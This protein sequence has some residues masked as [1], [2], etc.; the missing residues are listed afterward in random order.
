MNQ[1]SHNKW[2]GMSMNPKVALFLCVAFGVWAKANAQSAP[3]TT[4]TLMAAC[5][6][7]ISSDPEKRR[8]KGD[9]IIVQNGILRNC[10]VEKLH[11]AYK[12]EPKPAFGGSFQFVLATLA[13][14]REE[15]ISGYLVTILDTQLTGRPPDGVHVTTLGYYPV[16]SALVQIRSKT[17][18][19]DLFHR[20]AYAADERL[21]RLIT[22]VLAETNGRDVALFLLQPRLERVKKLSDDATAQTGRPFVFPEHKNLERMKQLL[23]SKDEIVPPLPFAAAPKEA[24]K[25]DA[26][27]FGAP[28]NE[29]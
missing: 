3:Q 22:W 10:L 26:N 14:M 9:F 20:T 25:G 13:D 12:R 7:L 28:V 8:G 21:L 15:S 29:K 16:A 18:N 5:D 23:E 17:L 11:E 24:P 2:K 27:P 19:H 6:D 4:S 1:D